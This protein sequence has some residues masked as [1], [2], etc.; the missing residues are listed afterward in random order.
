MTIKEKMKSYNFWVSL[1]SAVILIL[2]VIGAQVGFTID[3]NFANDLITS[4][5]SILV[6]LGIIVTPTSSSKVVSQI[7]ETKQ[8]DE[9]TNNN[10]NET[11]LE[12]PEI[13]NEPCEEEQLEKPEQITQIENIENENVE[14]EINCETEEQS[15]INS[16]LEFENLLNNQKEKFTN[17]IETYIGMLQAEIDNCKNNKTE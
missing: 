16:Y 2:K 11:N 13:T 4:L 1:A 3:A 9:T 7:I 8:L 17:D 6:L 5:C 12:Q 15:I 14:Q 10:Q